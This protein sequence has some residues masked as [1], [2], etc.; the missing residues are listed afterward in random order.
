MRDSAKLGIVARPQMQHFSNSDVHTNHPKILKYRL[1]FNTLEIY[2]SNKVPYYAEAAGP[3]SYFE[4]K[5][6]IKQYL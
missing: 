5:G 2:I 3:K 1:G 4:L 6:F